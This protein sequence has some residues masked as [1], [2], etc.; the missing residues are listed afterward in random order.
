MATVFIT[1]TSSGIGLATAV[2]LA[3]RG[4]IVI[5]GMRNPQSAHELNKIIAAEHLP[6]TTI[7]LDVDDD[8]SVAQ[9]FE[10]VLAVHEHVDVLVNNAG[11][12]G[13]GSVEETSLDTFRSTM[14]TNF[15]G[16]LRC[17]KAVLPD[18]LK[19]RAGCILNISS[20]A[21]RV[22][23]A[24][25]AAYAASKHAIEAVSECLA[26]EIRSF[27]V[28]VVVVE[29]GPI[30][31]PIFDKAFKRAGGFTTKY[32][33][34]RRLGAMF[35]ALLEQPTSPYVVGEQVREIIEGGSW[36]FRYPA[37]PFAPRAF[38]WRAKTPDD[39][40]IAMIAGS[41]ENWAATVK[42]EFGVDL[43]LS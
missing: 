17:I 41:D 22:A 10:Q 1:G 40:W 6:V 39:D 13:P 42:R 33:H 18:M 7:T 12:A 5:A 24:P 26:Q 2:T 19:R 29:P 30:A 32:P 35:A 36:Q 20:I 21:G 27:N 37:G 14:E 4:H 9:A 11:I 25:Q 28:R 38:A 34:T 31:T 3:R 16:T 8:A 15:F 43:A 23:L